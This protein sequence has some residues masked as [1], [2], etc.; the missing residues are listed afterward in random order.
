MDG[1]AAFGHLRGS[2]AIPKLGEIDE[3]WW[4]PLQIGGWLLSSKSFI[5]L[6]ESF[7]N[8]WF[9]EFWLEG[10]IS[11][12]MLWSML[13][14][15]RMFQTVVMLENTYTVLQDIEIYVDDSMATLLLR[16]LKECFFVIIVVG[17]V[18]MLK[19]I[20][21]TW[22]TCYI[23]CVFWRYIHWWC[24]CFS[25]VKVTCFL[26]LFFSNELQISSC[27]CVSIS[28]G[29]I[30]S[31]KKEQPE[32]RCFFGGWADMASKCPKNAQRNWGSNRYLT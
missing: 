17:S 5:F 18:L 10:G 1:G 22:N 13:L 19:K 31:E 12:G 8:Q 15:W 7:S 11:L 9:W 25:Y 21:F 26:W 3:F 20:L 4:G 29:Q 6:K 23:E 2:C 27:S 16:I 14:W 30:C 24:W 28:S 32:H